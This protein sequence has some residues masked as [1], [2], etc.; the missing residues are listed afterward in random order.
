MVDVHGHCDERFRPLEDA[1]RRNLDNGLDK[2]A[3]LAVTL[4]GESVVDLWGG[5]R[6]YE[7][8]QPWDSD[9]V[10]RV[11]SSSKVMVII[12]VLMLV[13]RGL[14]DLDEP[15]AT[16]WPEF[17]RHGKGSITSRQVLVHRSGLPGLGRKVSFGEIGDPQRCASIVEDAELWYE[18]G[19]I[20]CYH[21]QTFGAILGEVITRVS[22]RRFD[23]FFRDEIADPLDADFQFGLP[24][25]EA[26][27]VSA[28]WPPTNVYELEHPMAAAVMDELGASGE[29]IDPANLPLV[30]ASGSGITNARAMARAGTII[31]LGGEVDGRRYM[32]ADIIAEAGSE[33]SYAEDLVVGWCRYG[34]GFGLHLDDYP[35]PT[36]TTVHWG[37]YGGS[38]CTMDPATGITSAYAQ[39]QL[40]TDD[41]PRGDPRRMEFWRLLGEISATL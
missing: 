33:Q 16:Y 2:G 26:G 34:L 11:F 18:P 9:T 15:I 6:D 17:A 41:G 29:W 28:I 36:P 13:D 39:N 12:M 31:A 30:I 38:Y 22:G 32:G 14:L 27:R 37:G 21:P 7:M 10:V 3:S 24:V 23:E 5:T 25:A 19:T 20:S 8:V 4:G 1:F 35:A 40:L